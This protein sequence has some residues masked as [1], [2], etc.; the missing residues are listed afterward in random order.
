YWCQH[1]VHWTIAHWHA[2]VWLD[3]TQVEY[4]GTYQPGR[5]VRRRDEEEVLEKHL[6]PSFK[7]GRISVSCWAAVIHGSQTPLV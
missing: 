4:T 5:K 6:V 7:S 3:E 2:A 1:W